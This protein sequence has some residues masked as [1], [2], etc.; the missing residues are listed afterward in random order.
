MLPESLLR[1]FVNVADKA[2]LGSYEGLQKRNDMIDKDILGGQTPEQKKETAIAAARSIA[3]FYGASAS[4]FSFEQCMDHIS[5]PY[6]REGV[7]KL[8]V[9]AR[10]IL[11]T[12]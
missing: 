5:A 7:R 12:L 10:V 4:N 3:G 6:V 11:P 9:K 2:P 8:G 1:E